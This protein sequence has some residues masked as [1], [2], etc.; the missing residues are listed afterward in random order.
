MSKQVII[1]GAQW[2]DEGKGKVVDY[3]TTFVDAV[4][5]FQGG[6][7]AGHTLVVDGKKVVLHLI[8]SGILH[9]HVQCLIG[10]GVVLSLDALDQELNN[11]KDTVPDATS[12]L[13]ISWACP[14]LLP[15]HVALDQ[16]REAKRGQLAIGTTGRGIGPAYEDKV[17]RRGLRV[18]DLKYPERLKEKLWA[19][20]DYHNFQLSQYYGVKAIGPQEVY[21]KLLEQSNWT[22]PLA[23]DVGAVLAAY[24]DSDGTLLFEGAQ[25][26]LLDIDLGTYPYVTS[27]NT[28]A[29]A[30]ATGTGLGPCDFN[31]IL[32]MTKAYATRVGGGPFPTELDDDVGQ[33]LAKRGHEFGATTG[34]ARRCGWLDMVA[35]RYVVRANSLTHLA[36]MKVDVLDALAEINICVAYE[37]KGERLIHMPQDALMLADCKPIYESFPGWQCDTSAIDSYDQLP[38]AARHYM[39]AIAEYTGVPIALVSVGADREQ[40]IFVET[41]LT[42]CG[43]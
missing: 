17:A 11:L 39:N 27:S 34:R 29:G 8:P 23:T 40:T 19:L 7:N 5:R 22:L 41:L 35:L 16:A 43:E 21:D 1:L 32:G 2:G 13:K 30:A 15:Y 3:L 18:V 10:N 20:A 38:E 25:G 26:A 31:M 12:R 14:L 37:Y 33:L 9:D 36:M 42:R 6:H 28:T 4:V 24:S